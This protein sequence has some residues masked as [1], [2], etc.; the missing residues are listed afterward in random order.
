MYHPQSLICRPNVFELRLL[1]HTYLG[2]PYSPPVEEVIKPIIQRQ[3]PAYPG[4]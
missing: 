3:C 1:D 2:S 4:V